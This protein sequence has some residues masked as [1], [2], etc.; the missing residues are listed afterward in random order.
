MLVKNCLYIVSHDMHM[1]T[2]SHSWTLS[3]S[4]KV[5]DMRMRNELTTTMTTHLIDVV[6]FQTIR[7]LS[8]EGS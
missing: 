6:W 3:N 5:G 1:T 4:V 2:Y 7:R 8:G